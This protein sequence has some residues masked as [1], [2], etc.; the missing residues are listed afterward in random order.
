MKLGRQIRDAFP[1]AQPGALLLHPYPR[2]GINVYLAVR[3]PAGDRFGFLIYN[4]R[5]RKLLDQE[6]LVVREPLKENTWYQLGSRR[7]GYLGTP[8]ALQ[9]EISLAPP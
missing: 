7:I 6:V 4:A 9:P 2:Q 5:D 1:H 3:V 8:A